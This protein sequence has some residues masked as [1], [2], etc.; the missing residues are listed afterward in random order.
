M[1]TENPFSEVARAAKL[2]QEVI[3]QQRKELEIERDLLLQQL[4]ALAG[5]WSKAAEDVDVL[6][7][8]QSRY[9]EARGRSEGASGVPLFGKMHA[10][11]LNLFERFAQADEATR[12]NFIVMWSPPNS[13]Y[14]PPYFSND[15]PDN[16]GKNL[17]RIENLA[18]GLGVVT[19]FPIPAEENGIARVPTLTA[20]A[21]LLSYSKQDYG[22][23]RDK[24]GKV[25]TPQSDKI[26]TVWEQNC[27]TEDL[28]RQTIPDQTYDTF[29]SAL[30]GFL[31]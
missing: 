8:L 12:R 29:E 27:I 2:R 24:I 15:F 17:F 18:A 14:T 9:E 22:I 1:F 6:A 31:R 23:S 20:S 21:N 30:D 7:A 4:M 13:F 26:T 5:P 28:L 11:A 25:F 3:D 19:L 10:A 16:S